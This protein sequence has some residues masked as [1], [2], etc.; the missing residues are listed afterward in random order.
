MTETDR[1]EL[2]NVWN[3]IATRSYPTG[4]TGLQSDRDDRNQDSR[5]PLTFVVGLPASITALPQVHAVATTKGCD[6]PGRDAK[7]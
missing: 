7:D 1:S 6:L 4:A 5:R 3:A 2:S